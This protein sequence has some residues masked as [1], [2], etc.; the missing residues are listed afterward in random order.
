MLDVIFGSPD[1]VVLPHRD[2][3]LDEA[4]LVAASDHRPTWVDVDLDPTPV[5]TAETETGPA[6]AE[7]VVVA[8]E[9]ETGSG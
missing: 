9:E 3:A 1:L 6:V 8:A 7:S 2:V 4:D 5:P